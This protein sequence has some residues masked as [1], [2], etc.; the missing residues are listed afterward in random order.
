MNAFV[1]TLLLADDDSDDCIFFKD[2]LDDLPVSVNLITV[3]DGVELM[4]TL[5]SNTQQLPDILFLDLNMPRKTG[6]EC[7]SEIKENERLKH[8]PIIILSTSL[9]MK[10]VNSLHD[11]GAHYYI[12]KPGEFKQLKKLIHEAILITSKKNTQRPAKENFILVP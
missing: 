11:M 7:L 12:R 8:L 10:V 5:S 6:F 3:N 1:H 2:A 4:Q 9:D